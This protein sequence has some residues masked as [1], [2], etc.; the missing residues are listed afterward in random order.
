MNPGY[1]RGGE[2]RDAREIRPAPSNVELLKPY[3]SS[4][5]LRGDRQRTGSKERELYFVVHGG[6]VLVEVP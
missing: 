2:G 1:S 4:Q 5:R 3:L 6:S